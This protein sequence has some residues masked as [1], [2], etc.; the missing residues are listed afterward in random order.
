MREHWY[1][2]N[3]LHWRLDVA[4]RED[5]C[6][7]RRSDAA[8]IFSGIKHI[9]INMLSLDKS[10]KTGIKRKMKRAA[11]DEGYLSTV[12]AGYGGS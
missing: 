3:K 1:I 7:I 9:A 2:E 10:F 11:M 8:E 6:R 4:M 12:L 5:E